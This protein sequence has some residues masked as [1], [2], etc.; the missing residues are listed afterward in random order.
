M[1]AFSPNQ[2]KADLLLVI[3]AAATFGFSFTEVQTIMLLGAAGLIAAVANLAEAHI[4]V[5]TKLAA[6][7]ADAV[8]EIRSILPAINE[9]VE[10]GPQTPEAIAKAGGSKASK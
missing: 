9:L 5:G 1:K 3:S 4:H 2:I 6:T 7:I 8:K 10:K